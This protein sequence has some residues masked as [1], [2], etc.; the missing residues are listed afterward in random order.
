MFRP[1]CL[2]QQKDKTI[3]KGTITKRYLPFSL[4]VFI[5][6]QGFR[7]LTIYNGTINQSD[8]T[9][10][11]D[12]VGRCGM[13]VEDAYTLDTWSHAIWDS[14]QRTVLIPKLSCFRTY[15]TLQISLNTFPMLLLTDLG[16][17]PNYYVKA[18]WTNIGK[19]ITGESSVPKM[20][21]WSVL[22]I[23]SDSK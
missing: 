7:H 21:I 22:L 17:L 8:F 18:L 11:H 3:S 5:I 23:K 12:L 4:I 16:F 13:S 19:R 9:T 6:S 10:I 2:L 1:F 15:K 14:L 20:L